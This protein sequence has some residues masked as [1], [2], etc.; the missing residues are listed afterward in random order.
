[1]GILNR[2]KKANN[3]GTATGR[4]SS[5]HTTDA[6]TPPI[7]KDVVGDH[8]NVGA[9]NLDDSTFPLLTLRTFLATVIASM[10]G[11]IFG[12]DTGQISGFLE[13]PVFLER[14][15]EYDPSNSSARQEPGV[16]YGYYFTNVR[17]GLIVAL[18]STV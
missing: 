16:G 11:M 14:F 15:G 13:M 3:V 6:A 9:D 18:V 5:E 8:E 2:S 17:S 4:S 7:G 10:G 12:Y 1:M